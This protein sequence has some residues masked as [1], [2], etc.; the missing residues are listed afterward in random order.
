MKALPAP[1]VLVRQWL[2]DP[3]AITVA[4]FAIAGV[5]LGVSVWFIQRNLRHNDPGSRFIS[6]QISIHRTDPMICLWQSEIGAHLGEGSKGYWLVWRQPF[7]G[8]VT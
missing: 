3:H 1:H 8:C 7:T 2:H 4:A 5:F 6:R